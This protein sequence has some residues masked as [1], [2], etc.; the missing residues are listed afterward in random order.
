MGCTFHLE[1]AIVSF[2]F[3]E[4]GNV[5]YGKPGVLSHCAGMPEGHWTQRGGDH[6]H[7]GDPGGL[8]LYNMACTH[9]SHCRFN[10]CFWLHT[11][12]APQGWLQ[13][14]GPLV[15]RLLPPQSLGGRATMC[16][17]SRDLGEGE[18][19]LASF[20]CNHSSSLWCQALLASE[21]QW[22]CLC[23]VFPKAGGAHPTAV[24]GREGC[25]TFSQLGNQF[26]GTSI[27]ACFSCGTWGRV[28][29]LRGPPMGVATSSDGTL[30]EAGGASLEMEVW[31]PK[32]PSSRAT[33]PKTIS[34]E[35]ET[36]HSIILCNSRTD[37]AK[38]HGQ[39]G[40][41]RLVLSDQY[42]RAWA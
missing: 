41:G 17:G 12:G 21:L 29:S 4:V 11:P 32:N 6:L 2:F 28:D 36:Y 31:L 37:P 23:F 26:G 3:W 38:R 5:L 39:P 13:A 10:D 14:T 9:C 7:I 34:S 22:W 30:V 35:N 1:V 8:I 20:T 27:L 15:S 19:H 33:L 42:Y 16:V 25:N 24:T 40:I 18:S